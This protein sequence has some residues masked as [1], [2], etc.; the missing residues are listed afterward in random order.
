MICVNPHLSQK[1]PKPALYDT[2]YV[3]NWEK[4]ILPMQSVIEILTDFFLRGRAGRS[5]KQIRDRAKRVRT[6]EMHRA[7]LKGGTQD[8]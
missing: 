1:E 6:P 7:Q 3:L 4:Q 8:G 2:F 5:T